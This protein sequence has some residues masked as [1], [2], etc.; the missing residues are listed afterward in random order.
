[1]ILLLR[2]GHA[3]KAQLANRSNDGPGALGAPVAGLPGKQGFFQGANSAI[4]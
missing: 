1:V 3:R 4:V 2:E